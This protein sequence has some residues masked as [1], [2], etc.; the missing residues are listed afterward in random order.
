MLTIEV[1][2]HPQGER[3]FEPWIQDYE[4]GTGCLFHFHWDDISDEGVPVF[5]ELFTQQARRWHPRADGL[6]LGPRIPITMERRTVMDEDVD[7]AV[8]DHAEYIAYTVRADLISQRAAD[9]LTRHQS[10]RS[11]YWERTP[12]S[13][14]IS[15]RSV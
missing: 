5:A 15:R 7:V 1:K 2:R 13:Y 4:D 10:E 9:H 8:D 3:Y 11:P 12:G 14:S 6:P